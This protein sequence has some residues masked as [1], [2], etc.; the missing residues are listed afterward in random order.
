M[1]LTNCNLWNS[2][3]SK[4]AGFGNTVL[5]K[6]K[7]VAVSAL[8]G[9]RRNGLGVGYI[10]ERTMYRAATLVTTNESGGVCCLVGNGEC[11]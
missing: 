4:R 6:K 1:P 8:E 2:F 11:G 3:K 7:Q 5:H 9:G 10:E